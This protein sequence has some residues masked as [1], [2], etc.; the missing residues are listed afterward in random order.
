MGRAVLFGERK[1]QNVHALT[2][3]QHEVLSFMWVFYEENDQPPTM[4]VICQEFCFKSLNAASD[5]LR[6]LERKGYLERNALGKFKFA[7]HVHQCM[8]TCPV[9]GTGY[10]AELR[11][12]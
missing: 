8:V 1:F 12:A 3:K 10:D 7:S 11:A 9:S 2:Q 4:E 5:H 6:A